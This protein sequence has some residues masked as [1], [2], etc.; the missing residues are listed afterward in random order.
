MLT[1]H[2]FRTIEQYIFEDYE[3]TK[4]TDLNAYKNYFGEKRCLLNSFYEFFAT[5]WILPSLLA[6]P[7]VSY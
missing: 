4:F 1:P 7:L 2:I 3:E 6:V 5:W